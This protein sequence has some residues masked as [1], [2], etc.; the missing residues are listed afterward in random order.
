MQ[1]SG[2]DVREVQKNDSVFFKDFC[3]KV[4]NIIE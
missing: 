4:E 2:G 3:Y 1:R